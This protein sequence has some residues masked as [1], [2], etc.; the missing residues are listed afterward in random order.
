MVHN[1]SLFVR[2][3]SEEFKNSTPS[4]LGAHADPFWVISVGCIRNLTFDSLSGPCLGPLK[5]NGELVKGQSHYG[6]WYL[7]QALRGRGERRES[8]E[9]LWPNVW[10]RS[11]LGEASACKWWT[12]VAA[13]CLSVCWDIAPRSQRE[14]PVRALPWAVI[15]CLGKGVGFQ[16]PAHH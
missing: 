13:M 12:T 3:V 6:W 14:T 8:R 7:P 4:L 15:L 5:Q 10:S 2:G 11:R 9:R 1:I 16:L